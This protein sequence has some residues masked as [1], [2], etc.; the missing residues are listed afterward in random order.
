MCVV[1]GVHIVLAR[2]SI[3]Q[4]IFNQLYNNLTGHHELHVPVLYECVGDVTV[5]KEGGWL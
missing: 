1:V 3:S 4:D 2:L 5:C